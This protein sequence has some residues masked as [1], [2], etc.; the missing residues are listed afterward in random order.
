MK[1]RSHNKNKCAKCYCNAYEDLW[2]QLCILFDPRPNG[3]N[4][5]IDVDCFDLNVAAPQEGWVLLRPPRHVQEVGGAPNPEVVPIVVPDE[6]RAAELTP[7][8]PN[9]EPAPNGLH[10]AHAPDAPQAEPAPDVDNN[11]PTPDAMHAA[12]APDAP[13]AEPPHHGLQA[14]IAHDAPQAEPVPDNAGVP[15]WKEAKAAHHSPVSQK[16]HRVFKLYSV[17]CKPTE[18]TIVDAGTGAC[19]EVRT[20]FPKHIGGVVRHSGGAW[21]LYLRKVALTHPP[22]VKNPPFGLIDDVGSAVDTD[23][24]E[25]NFQFL[26][27]KPYKGKDPVV[28][29]RE[30]EGMDTD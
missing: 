4:D 26:G 6:A 23:E 22:R 15:L 27:F 9:N 29:K 3:Q 28:V 17:E 19:V 25:A 24:E 13:M 12:Q 8:G 16:I 30:S 1:R 7:D 18:E 10:V 14:F 11:E 2:E 20:I 21:G 5:V